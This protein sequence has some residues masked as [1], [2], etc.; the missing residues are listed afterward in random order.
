MNGSKLICYSANPAK[1][2]S[3]KMAALDFFFHTFSHAVNILLLIT[4]AQL[5]FQTNMTSYP[6]EAWYRQ[7]AWRVYF[8]LFD[9]H[10]VR[11]IAN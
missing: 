2:K 8:A 5:H 7:N 9:L 6:E 4:Q 11:E 1:V 10:S 3:C